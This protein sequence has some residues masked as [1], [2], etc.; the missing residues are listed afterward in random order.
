MKAAGSRQQ[1]AGRAGQVTGSSSRA[2]CLLPSAFCLS[3]RGLTLA[4]LLISM[5]ILSMMSVVLA[6]MSHAVNSAWSYTKGVEET[7]LQARAALERI[8]F[9]VLQTGSYRLAGKPTRMGLVVLRRPFGSTDVPDVLVLW[10]GGRNGGMAASG[11]QSRL[12]TVGELLIYTTDG[13]TPNEL[14]EVAFPGQTTPFDFGAAGLATQVAGLLAADTAEKIPLCDR[15]RVSS[16]NS[17]QSTGH[18]RFTQ[19]VLPSDDELATAA[20]L[21][22]NWLKLSWPLGQCTN[23]SGMRQATVRIELQ[24]EPDGIVRASDTVAAIP[25]FGSASVRSLYEP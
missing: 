1:T 15:L 23:T 17:M 22:A 18:L 12:P 25:F 5:S 19:T 6:G 20:P 4:E 21:T 8:E 14:L 2:D 16:L 9:M 13:K 11:V 3:R 24:I 10:T 7:D